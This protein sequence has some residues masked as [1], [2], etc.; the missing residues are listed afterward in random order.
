MRSWTAEVTTFGAVVRIEQ[1]STVLPLRHYMDDTNAV[2]RFTDSPR[3]WVRRR[4]SLW[5]LGRG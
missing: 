2:K 1:V 3:Q 5:V 4:L